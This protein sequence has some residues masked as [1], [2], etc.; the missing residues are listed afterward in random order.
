MSNKI[1]YISTVSFKQNPFRGTNNSWR[2]IPFRGGNLPA[3]RPISIALPSQLCL[4][5]HDLG[6]VSMGYA[7]FIIWTPND[8]S[9]SQTI[10]IF[11]SLPS[12]KKRWISNKSSN[13]QKMTAQKVTHDFFGT[14]LNLLETSNTCNCEQKQ[15]P[16]GNHTTVGAAK[17]GGG[18]SCPGCTITPTS[19]SN[20]QTRMWASQNFRILWLDL[21]ILGITN[22]IF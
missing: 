14:Y 21:E 9:L 12:F 8:F 13:Q 7:F 10:P 6:V 22:S 15:E 4:W 5:R 11:T 2:K 19:E 1:K 16:L 20:R 3:Y 18:G 17:V